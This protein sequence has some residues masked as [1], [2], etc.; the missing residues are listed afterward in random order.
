MASLKL[1]KD[2][3]D[4]TLHRLNENRAY[5]Y[6]KLK[7]LLHEKLEDLLLITSDEQSP[8]VMMQ[9]A[10]I[11]ETA[12]LNEV[13]FLQEVVRESL[14]RGVAMVATGNAQPR[15]A[16]P[17]PGIRMSVSASHTKDD[18]DKALD[19]LGEAVDVV[20]GR[21]HDEEEEKEDT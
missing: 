8:I 10:E 17:P 2:R 5:L 18:I 21:F 1:L 14:A 12:Y 20:M 15:A 3:P 9:V 19:V 7:T 16:D 13:V 6:M 11:P 4:I